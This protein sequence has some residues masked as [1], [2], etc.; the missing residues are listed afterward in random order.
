MVRVRSARARLLQMM[1]ETSETVARRE[2]IATYDRVHHMLDIAR[3]GRDCEEAVMLLFKATSARGIY[4]NN[5]LQRIMRDVIA[6]SNHITQN[7]DDNAGMLGDYLL[8]QT[9]PPMIFGL[10][11]VNVND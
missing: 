11:A 2:L 10:S 5:P 3:V 4:L 8:G 1:A 6:A 7:A 9:L